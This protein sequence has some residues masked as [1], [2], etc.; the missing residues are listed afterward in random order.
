MG[1]KRGFFAELQHQNQLA[2][3]RAV[4]QSQPLR[5]RLTLLQ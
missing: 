3:K 1:K 2:Q 5:T 4:Q